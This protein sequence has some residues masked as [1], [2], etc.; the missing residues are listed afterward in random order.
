MTDA[1]EQTSPTTS[2]V[3][4]T[5]AVHKEM[6]ACDREVLKAPHRHLKVLK[7]ELKTLRLGPITEES[8]D[9]K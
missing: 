3:V 1:W 7:A 8:A 5:A 6:H 9:R 4:R 2:I